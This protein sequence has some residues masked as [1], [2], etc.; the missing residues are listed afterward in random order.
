MATKP[1]IGAL[2]AP[3]TSKWRFYLEPQIDMSPPNKSLSL[4][5]VNGFKVED[6]RQIMFWTNKPNTVVYCAAALG[7]NMKV[8][9]LQQRFMG[10]GSTSTAN[11]HTDDIMALGVSPNRQLVV[12]GSLGATPGILLWDAETLEIKGRTKLGRNT[13]AVSTIRF[14]KNGDYFFCSDKHNDSNVYCYSAKD[15]SLLAKDKCGSDAV[16]DA[17]T[18]A[19]STYACATKSGLWF[20]QYSE[21]GGIKK[22]RG[23]FGSSPRNAMC[24]VAYAGTQNCFLSGSIDG[25][26]YFWDGISCTKVRPTHEGSVMTIAW[27]EDVIYSSGF[28]D[29]L[30]KLSTID[31]QIIKTYTLP[32]YAK[33]ID[34]FN[35]RILVGTKCGRMITIDGDTQKEIMHGHWTGETWGL[36]IDSAGIVYTT[37]DDNT[38]LAFNPKTKKVEKEGVINKVPGKKYKIGGASTLSLLPPN[39]QARGIATNKAGHVALGLNDGQLSIR[40]TQNLGAEI[41]NDKSAK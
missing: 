33:N 5:F 18:G 3:N 2:V 34:A 26:I 27:S 32:S 4:Q 1:W 20:F 29:N 22:N 35:K 28:R 21:G 12:T 14:S 41:F 39:Q 17:E 19:N 24:C 36:S 30:L 10:S 9:T 13:R 16:I 15:M 8:D 7:I 40:T 25:S 6:S 23:I 31:G 11:G 37:A 38:V